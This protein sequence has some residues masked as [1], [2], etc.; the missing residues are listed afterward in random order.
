MQDRYAG[1]TPD[2]GKYV[3]LRHI[4]SATGLRLGI[5]CNRTQPDEV[6]RAGNNDGRT[7]HHAQ[8][9]DQFEAA[10]PDIYAGLRPFDEDDYQ[11]IENVEKAGILP[12]GTCFFNEFLS[13]GV[14][15]S[16]VAQQIRQDW[17]NRAFEKLRD[18]Q[19]VFCDPDTGPSP[20]SMLDKRHTKKGP[21]YAHPEEI[22][23]HL[24]SGQSVIVIRFI[25]QYRGGVEQAIRDTFHLLGTQYG[26]PKSRG[27]AV[28][29][30]R[31]KNSTY[32]ILPTIDHEDALRRAIEVLKDNPVYRLLFNLYQYPPFQKSV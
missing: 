11:S 22:C 24:N 28:E 15:R 9:P 17:F 31:G 2:F 12:I 8:L 25:R 29:F 27:F 18:C 1:D 7:R 23:A 20:L 10:A 5:N 13:Y 16:A 32:F 30:P 14:P 21:K 26:V 19:I 4:Q 3:L 6:D